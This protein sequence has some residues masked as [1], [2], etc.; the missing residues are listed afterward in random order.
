MRTDLPDGCSDIGSMTSLDIERGMDL[1]RDAGWNQTPQDWSL[2][3]RVGEAFGIRND[4]GL[5]IA[6]AVVLHYPP[7][8]A[9]IG[10]VLV[11]P[12]WR[13]RGLASRLIEHAVSR[14]RSQRLTPML[15]ATPAGREVYAHMGFIDGDSITRWRGQAEGGGGPNALEAPEAA[16][17]ANGVA[18]DK[19][20]F[21]ACRTAILADFSARPGSL[22]LCGNAAMLWCRPGRTATQIGPLLAR[23]EDDAVTL[24][25]AA[26]D[27]LR[28]P[29]VLD[30]PN[31]E[32]SM[33]RALADRGFVAERSF[34]RMAMGSHPLSTLGAGMRVIAGPELG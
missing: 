22:T 27:R 31:R 26:L 14:A 30:V 17:L 33:A 19:A 2:L 3:L 5:I 8:F 23:G 25:G 29:V 20:A 21:G 32:T 16:A 9:W 24:C 12:A 4:S 11:D 6:T 15:D 18:A 13:R 10:M 34:T 1:V 7:A 28:C